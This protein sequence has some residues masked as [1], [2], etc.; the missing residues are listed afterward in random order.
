MPSLKTKISD[1]SGYLEISIAPEFSITPELSSAPGISFAPEYISPSLYSTEA[2]A[3]SEMSTGTTT[4]FLNH[5]CSQAETPC[6]PAKSKIILKNDCDSAMLDLTL[7]SRKDRKEVLFISE[8]IPHKTFALTFMKNGVYEIRFRCAHS[9]IKF[10]GNLNI[11]DP[12]YFTTSRP[13]DFNSDPQ[14]MWLK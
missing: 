1:N 14:Q 7:V 11:V 12:A 13:D 5:Y 3:L 9:P 6:Y 10:Q 4:I 2:S 8:I